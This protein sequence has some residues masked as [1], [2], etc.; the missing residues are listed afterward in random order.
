MDVV[1]FVGPAGSGKSHRA[2][3]I[4]YQYNCDMIIDDGLVIAGGKILAGSSAKREG[5]KMGA[6]KRAIFV[7]PEHREEVR[8]AIW[9]A[10]PQRILILGTSDDMIERITDALDLPRPETVVR[11]EDVAT[12]AQI[13]LARR[14][15][16]QEGKHVI[17]APTLEVKRT[18]SGYLVD[19][20]RFLLKRH[21]DGD[22]LAVE[23]SVVR[24]TFSSLGKFFIADTVVSSIAIHAAESVPGVAR[25][26]KAL[27]EST[28]EGVTVDMDIILR[29]G[30][31]VWTVLREAQ[32]AVKESIE[33]MTALNVLSVNLLGKRLTL[34]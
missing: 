2:S 14:K 31:Q 15:R 10:K 23:K 5:T 11:I 29:Y 30:F 4:A 33:H 3:M 8:A 6:V 25:V 27:V 13:R 7:E 18:M 28:Q 21:G 12:P 16:R 20:L 17:P 22:P 32:S 9:K 1:A 19:P 34:S 24:P 26:D